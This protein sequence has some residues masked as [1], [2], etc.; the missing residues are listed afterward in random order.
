MQWCAIVWRLH[1]KKIGIDPQPTIDD[2]TA[3]H[4]I[5]VTAAG[6]GSH[7]LSEWGSTARQQQ[8]QRAW[9][10]IASCDARAEDCVAGER[11]R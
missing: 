3:S 5:A 10:L 9:H 7:T 4:T 11:L 6:S 1:G 2:E 8:H